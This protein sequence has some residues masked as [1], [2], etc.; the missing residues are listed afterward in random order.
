MHLKHPYGDEMPSIFSTYKTNENRVT[1]TE[2][3]LHQSEGS[4]GGQVSEYT[5]T[6][7]IVCSW[8]A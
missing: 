1:S 5:D 4:F 2:Q 7:Q 6:I 8:N 3:T